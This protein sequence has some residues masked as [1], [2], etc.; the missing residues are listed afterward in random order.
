MLNMYFKKISALL[1]FSS[2]YFQ[3]LCFASCPECPPI[4]DAVKTKTEKQNKLGVILKK[5][6]DYLA[7][8][9]NVNSSIKIKIQSN[10]LMTNV[11]IETVQNELTDLNKNLKEK[12]CDQCKL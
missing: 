2:I 9:P 12:G 8:N 1:I 7:Q 3:N 10:I 6:Q 11:Q 5:N 4:V